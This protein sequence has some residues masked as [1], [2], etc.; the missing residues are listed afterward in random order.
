LKNPLIMRSED[1]GDLIRLSMFLTQ[2]SEEGK[3]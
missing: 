2:I 1:Q 3:K